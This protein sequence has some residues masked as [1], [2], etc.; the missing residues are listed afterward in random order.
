VFTG[1]G[2]MHLRL[3]DNDFSITIEPIKFEV[4]SIDRLGLNY[5]SIFIFIIQTQSI[6]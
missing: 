5:K 6:L 2:K 1:A 4:D 3:S